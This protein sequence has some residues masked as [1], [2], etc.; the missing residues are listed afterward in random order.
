MNLTLYMYFFCF[1]AGLNKQ[2]DPKSC[3]QSGKKI[4]DLKGACSFIKQVR[5]E[6][7]LQ[8]EHDNFFFEKEGHRFFE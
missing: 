8:K 2:A 5:V 1:I 6:L 4:K 7:Y 3:L